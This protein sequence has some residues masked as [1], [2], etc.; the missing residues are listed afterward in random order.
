MSS[1]CKEP[2]ATPRRAETDPTTLLARRHNVP[3]GPGQSYT[4]VRMLH[5]GA[6]AGGTTGE[7]GAM[8]W[9]LFAFW[10]VNYD[11]TT[12]L[13]S[14]TLHETLDTAS[15]FGVPYT[16]L[17]RGAGLADYRPGTLLTS[18]RE[19]IAALRKDLVGLGEAVEQHDRTAD[20]DG[21]RLA[22]RYR[23]LRE[24][25]D[26]AARGTGWMFLSSPETRAV[27]R[28]E[29]SLTLQAALD[30]YTWLCEDLARSPAVTE[31]AWATA[32]PPGTWST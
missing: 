7:L 4:T 12:R 6:Q 8:A 27:A 15:D 14:H 16:M 2:R 10:R 26:S 31:P 32:P 20:P 30:E 21:A 23:A 11:H 18:M 25:V 28:R 22:G 29:A 1:H 24:K 5:L 19:T 13:A 9:A 17:D 3:L